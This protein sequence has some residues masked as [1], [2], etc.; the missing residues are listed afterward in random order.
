[1]VVNPTVRADTD[2]WTAARID[3]WKRGVR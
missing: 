2:Q 1:V 3:E